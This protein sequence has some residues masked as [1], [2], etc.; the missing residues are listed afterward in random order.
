MTSGHLYLKKG[1]HPLSPAIAGA[2]SSGPGASL[3]NSAGTYEF[4]REGQAI[5][6]APV[7]ALPTAQARWA[8]SR[9]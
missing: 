3:A 9:E 5:S 1:T 2:H 7:T 6:C 8:G 4:A